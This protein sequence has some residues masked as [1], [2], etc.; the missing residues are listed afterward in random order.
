MNTLQ[1]RCYSGISAF[2][3]LFVNV[4]KYQQWRGMAVPVLGNLVE[5]WE[6]RVV[7]AASK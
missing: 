6:E 2:A 7:L 1:V 5:E 3:D 4:K